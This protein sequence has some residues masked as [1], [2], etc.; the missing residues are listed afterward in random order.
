MLTKIRKSSDSLI[1]R[2]ILG[3]IV[4]SFVGIGA[5]S[6]IG[7]N[8]PDYVVSFSNIEPISMETFQVTK[9]R[10]TD[11]IQRQN[12]I[13]LTKDNGGKLAIDSIVLKKMI[14]ESMINYLAKQYEFDINSDK[15][16]DFVKKFPYFKNQNG[17]FDLEIFK[18]AFQNS[19][20]KKEEYLLS[21]KKHLIT[22]SLLSIFMDSFVPPK[23]M[24]KNMI[25]Y[26]S[27]E[28]IVDI[29][30]IDLYHQQ[31][32]YKPKNISTQQFKHF[33]KENLDL[34]VV[35]ELRSFGYLKADKNFLKKKL[36]ITGTELKQIFEENKEQFSSNDFV[37]AKK[38]IKEEVSR[39]RA[40]EFLNELAKNFE[41]DVSSGLS[42]Q[43]IA[44]KHELEV[45]NVNNV[46]ISEMNSSNISEY[47]EIADSVFAMT[48]GEVSSPIDIQNQ[49]EI[50]L[51]E[52]N[53][54]KQSVQQ[55]FSDVEQKIKS[56][57][58]KR[59]LVFENIKNI[60]EMQKNFDIKAIEKPLLKNKGI[61]SISNVY[62]TRG[63]LALK[64]KLPPQLL[65]NIFAIDKEN[66]TTLVD[67]GKKVYF[68][69]LKNIKT[70]TVKAKK[71]E[72]NS[73]DEFSNVIR[74]AIF[75]ELLT[76]LTQKNQMKLIYNP[77]KTD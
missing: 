23:V 3:L 5:V 31:K 15:V 48:E 8:K 74:E 4:I 60:E 53:N 25:R 28:R 29:F 2:I 41:R 27:E 62:L 40:E 58:E 16:I 46:S 51:I 54:V 64:D 20:K 12:G 75:Q 43:E 77:S 7:V 67:D 34:F 68:A 10:E 70:D 47:S 71:I 1:V 52:L 65:K 13:N 24:I 72:E 33:Y 42:L 17:E 11:S 45:K 73:S 26:M 57:L 49:N 39:E 35:P 37:K 6:F 55:S 38:Q 63:E 9:S 19:P 22:N 69:F 66:I 44:K 21:I 56:I 50:L 30:F 61:N 59:A 36:N 76:H 32:D 14:N 18:S